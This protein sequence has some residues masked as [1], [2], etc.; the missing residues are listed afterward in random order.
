MR[1]V[2]IT[3][4]RPLIGLFNEQRLTPHQASSQLQRWAFTLAGYDCITSYRSGE[5]HGNCDV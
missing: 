2:L 5:A 4:R 1:F 3:D